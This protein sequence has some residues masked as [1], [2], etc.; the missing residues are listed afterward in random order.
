MYSLFIHT[1]LSEK[2][3]EYNA[4]HKKKKTA[5]QNITI[6]HKYMYILM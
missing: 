4:M 6:S 2:K 1:F 5:T 3:A